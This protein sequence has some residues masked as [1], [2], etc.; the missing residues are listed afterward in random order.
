MR[1]VVLLGG[2]SE[3][4]DVSLASGCQVADALREAGHDVVALDPAGGAL[5]REDESKILAEGVGILPPGASVTDAA[6]DHSGPSDSAKL[7]DHQEI[8]SLGRGLVL[9]DVRRAS[10]DVVFPALHGG[11]GEDGTLQALLDL[12]GIAYA[13]TGMLGSVLAMD[14]DVTKRILR[15][16][17]VPTPDWLVDPTAQ[18]AVERLGLPLI[19][20]PVAGGSSVRL[21]L[22]DDAAQVEER[23]RLE[24]VGA[25][26]TGEASDMMYEA[27]VAGREFTVGILG[28]EALPVGEIVCEHGLFDYE[29]KYQ[30]GMADE[31]FPA[32]IPDALAQ[33]LQERALQVHRLLRLRDFSRVDFMVDG[34]GEA[35]CLEANTLPGMTANSLLPKAAR[36]AGMTFPELCDRIVH[37]AAERSRRGST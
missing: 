3:E 29:R 10:A 24:A 26:E 2:E 5:T 19:A 33:T 23:I 8:G 37:M 16:A 13:G 7:E 28:E 30:A 27:F 11:M 12:A 31:I 6:S 4:R 18:E 21:Y 36:A 17:G 9:D 1:V 15:D 25:S 35:W 20:K 14:K 32:E 22:L 34:E